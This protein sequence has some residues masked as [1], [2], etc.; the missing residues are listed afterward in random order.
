MRGKALAAMEEERGNPLNVARGLDGHG[1]V[2]RGCLVPTSWSL[3]RRPSWG[4]THPYGCFS[5]CGILQ[6]RPLR[7][8]QPLG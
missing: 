5:I 1:W 8:Q 7:L 2:F 3:A 6:Q 4:R